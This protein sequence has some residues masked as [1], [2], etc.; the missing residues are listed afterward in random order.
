M[1][2]AVE[3]CCHG[4]LDSI[5]ASLSDLEQRHA[6]KVDVLLICGDFQ[7]VRNAADLATMACPP[8]YRSMQTFY[9]YYTGA[10]VAPVLTIVIGGNH[11]ASNHLWELYYGGWL[12]PNIFFLGYAGVVNIGGV[13]IG[14]LTGIYNRKHY[15]MGHYEAPPFSDDDMRSTYHVRELEALRLKQLRQPLDI[16]LSHDWPQHIAKHGNLQGLYRRKAF[17]QPEV[18]DGSLGSPPAL[19][20]L[21]AL[22][23]S[24]WF[25]AHLHVKY[26]A[27][28][29]HDDGTATRFLSLDKCL[30]RRDFLQLVRLSGDG[31][32]P[33]LR[34]DAE[35]IAVLRA[36]APLFSVSRAR[37]PLDRASVAAATGGRYDFA[38]SEDE[39]QQVLD[40]AGGDLTVPLNFTQTVVAYSEG[41]PTVA[42]QS[43]FAEN[44]QTLRFV[45]TFKLPADF[46]TQ[47]TS[48]VRRPAVQTGRAALACGAAEAPA[49]VFQSVGPIWPTAPPLSEEIDLED[50]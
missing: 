38:A 49:G 16:M 42:A 34:Y 32:E 47:K 12:A 24:Y 3:G 46:R 6:V 1:L 31:S 14:G 20:L 48:V 50:D 11:E 28:V 8:K 26:A 39:K 45:A 21:Q 33:R 17:L 7:A 2:F 19:E 30:P 22:K 36:T 35:W 37:L 41:Q 9:K 25:S 15:Q 27:V 10:K 40:C 4:E 18:E 29:P 44:A 43:P 13:R 23:P 5:Y